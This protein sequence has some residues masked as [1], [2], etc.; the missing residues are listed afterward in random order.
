MIGFSGNN[1]IFTG[2]TKYFDFMGNKV[3]GFELGV[4]AGDDVWL[5]GKVIEGEFIFNGRLFLQDQKGGTIIDNFPKGD[6]QPGWKKKL[7]LDGSGYVLV[8]KND[9]VIFAY[10]IMGDTCR[11]DISLYRADG[12]IAATAGQGGVQIFVPF[13]VML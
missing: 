2:V 7:N 3:P 12:S 1:F 9:E 5:Q 11:V 8:D 10:R 13:N 4:E 6:P